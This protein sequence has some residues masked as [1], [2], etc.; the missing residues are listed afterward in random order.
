MSGVRDQA[1]RPVIRLH[2]LDNIVVA[3]ARLP[4]GAIV[5]SEGV[6]A[7]DPVPAGH[8]LATAFIAAGQPILKYGQVIGAATRDIPAGAH[9]HTQNLAVSA[10]RRDAERGAALPRYEPAATPSAARPYPATNRP[11]ASK[12]TVAPTA[13]SACAIT[14]AC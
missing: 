8:K 11:A 6:V 5:D 3:S 2:L 9:V 4:K 13:A 10:L 7:L 12:A 14:W 1:E